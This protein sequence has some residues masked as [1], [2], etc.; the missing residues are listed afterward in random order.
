MVNYIAVMAASPT[1]TQLLSA[2][3]TPQSPDN[4]A[5]GLYCGEAQDSPDP[6]CDF[7]RMPP[8][9]NGVE[10]DTD[11][12]G[13]L[14]ERGILAKRSPKVA[15]YC[16]GKRD[17]SSAFTGF[18]V[19]NEGRSSSDIKDCKN[20]KLIKLPNTPKAPGVGTRTYDTEHILEAQTV[21]RFFNAMGIKWSQPKSADS[22]RNS[23]AR[24]YETPDKG[25]K[26]KVPW[27][28]WMQRWWQ[29][30]DSFNSNNDLGSV[31]P[32]KAN[33]VK[34]ILLLEK[35]LNGV[36]KQGW[37]SGSR[38][39][40]E[41]SMKGWIRNKQWDNVAKILKAHILG[42]QYYYVD[43]IK[44]NLIRLVNRVEKRLSELD[45]ASGI[46]TKVGNN[47]GKYD[48]A[49]IPQ[50]LAAEWKKWVH[51]EH[52]RVENYVKGNIQTWARLAYNSNRPGNQKNKKWIEIFEVIR[53][54]AENLKK[55]ESN[56]TPIPMRMIVT[57]AVLE[58]LAIMYLGKL[59]RVPSTL[60]NYYTEGSV[61]AL[62]EATTF[63]FLV[64]TRALFWSRTR[65][66]YV[67]ERAQGFIS[68]LSP[69]VT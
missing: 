13:G 69:Q 5:E 29:P 10:P 40:G 54:T 12:K 42:W 31:Y 63:L 23:N 43:D 49:Y 28:Q 11:D 47:K 18:E 26:T 14:T 32:G 21:R 3:V 58:L 16:N 67:S 38:I 2:V 44:D 24:T 62:P 25:D 20:L 48:K 68:N 22:A 66:S 19:K 37:F 55:W 39:A 51:A 9:D 7:T 30:E 36:V 35:Y 56:G 1:V 45:S 59:E 17:G 15:T 65:K 50:D 4:S 41:R 60:I 8:L 52:T 57:V 27:C 6:D 61:F 53:D 64:G 34:E 33:Y 46:G